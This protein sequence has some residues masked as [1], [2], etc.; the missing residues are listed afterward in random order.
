MTTNATQTDDF[1]QQLKIA[2]P[3]SAQWEGMQGDDKVRHCQDC[4][5]NVYNLSG[6][7]KSEAEDLI[8][9]AEGR[10]CVR[11]LRRADGTVLVQDC[12]VG[13]KALRL[14][15]AKVAGLV[16]TALL[17]ACGRK[18]EQA[19]P[20]KTQQIENPRPVMGLVAPEH[21]VE[22]GRIQMGEVMI[23]EMGD[24][25]LPTPVCEEPVTEESN[26]AENQ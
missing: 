22:M 8:H 16:L 25:C 2:S 20:A 7:Q 6:M 3:C 15:L 21:G 23:E 10:V 11:M 14:K 4:K 24:V 13:V 18:T 1:L 19:P 5:L 9:N 17:F 26:P 12:P